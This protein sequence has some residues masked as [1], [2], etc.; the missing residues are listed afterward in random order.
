M[1][2][3]GSVGFLMRR[4][5]EGKKKPKM[6]TGVCGWEASEVELGSKRGGVEFGVRP[7]PVELD[8]AILF[9]LKHGVKP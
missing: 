9:Q 4:G 8:S 3:A 6:K 1:V 5:K 2:V 7:I